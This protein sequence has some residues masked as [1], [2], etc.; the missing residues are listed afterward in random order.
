MAT[1]LERYN[2]L[3]NKVEAAKQRSDKA[4]GALEH[5]MVDLESEFECSSLE[6]AEKLLAKMNKQTAILK[7]D[8]DETL[9]DFEKEYGDDLD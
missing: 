7:E 4:E 5:V 6:Q 1:D 2:K 8:F 3:K 9:D